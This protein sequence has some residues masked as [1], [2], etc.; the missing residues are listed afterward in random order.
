MSDFITLKSSTI[1]NSSF[2]IEGTEFLDQSLVKTGLNIWFSDTSDSFPNYTFK[3]FGYQDDLLF[4]DHINS[5]EMGSIVLV[6]AI[7]A[8]PNPPSDALFR[9][10]KKIGSGQVI[11][12]NGSANYCIIGVK[13]E[14]VGDAVE[15]FGNGQSTNVTV[16]RNVNPMNIDTRYVLIK[17]LTSSSISVTFNNTDTFES[18]IADGLTVW[19]FGED[20]NMDDVLMDSS[21]VY[22]TNSSTSQSDRLENFIQSQE[23]GKFIFIVSKGSAKTNISS[24]LAN[25]LKSQ[26]GSK[27]IDQYISSS[28]NDKWF[29]V[30]RKNSKYSL[31]ES[32]SKIE[33]TNIGS[34]FWTFDNPNEIIA[35]SKV[36]QRN[37]MISASS[38][39]Q[40]L[41]TS[42]TNRYSLI[43]DDQTAP[44]PTS[45]TSGFLMYILSEIDSSI[46]S[47]KSYNIKSTDPTTAV[48]M[49]TDIQNI[50]IGDIVVIIA[51]QLDSTFVMTSELAHMFETVGAQYSHDLIA[52]SSYVI[53][54]R[55]GSSTGSVPELFS[56][57]GPVSLFSNFSKVIVKPFIHIEAIS[58]S[59]TGGYSKFLINSTEVNANIANGINVLTLDENNGNIIDFTTFDTV[60]PSPMINGLLSTSGTFVTVNSSPS[61]NFNTGAFSAAVRFQTTSI[62]PILCRKPFNGGTNNGGWTL[63][64]EANGVINFM[65]DNGVGSYR[66]Q[67][68]PTNVIDADWHNIV[69]VRGAAGTL[70][71]YLDGVKLPVTIS[72]TIE[73]PL[74]VDSNASFVICQN[75]QKPGTQFIGTISDVSLWNSDIS[76]TTMKI[77]ASGQLTGNEPNLV[78]YWKLNSNLNDLS[79]V[80]NTGNGQNIT[81]TQ[82]GSTQSEL[83]ASK[84]QALQNGKIVAL[85]VLG[86][87]NT[88]LSKRAKDTMAFYLNSESVYT[89]TSG[90]SFCM[91]STI[92]PNSDLEYLLIS[93]CLSNSS[94]ETSC[95]VRFPIKSL[96]DKVVGYSFCVTSY[97]N[98]NTCKIMINGNHPTGSVG[99]GLN[100][101]TVDPVTG[102]ISEI[103]N[104]NTLSDPTAWS[105]FYQFISTLN[106]GVYICV[107]IKSSMGT[108]LTALDKRYRNMAFN[109]IGGCA[110]HNSNIGSYSLIGAKGITSG[111]GTES[112]S[113]GDSQVCVSSWEPKTP[114]NL[115]AS[116]SISNYSSI[117]SV[118]LL[119]KYYLVNNPVSMIPKSYA[120]GNVYAREPSYSLSNNNFGRVVKALLVAVSYKNS[121]AG[122]IQNSEIE[123][124]EHANVLIR[125][126]LILPENIKILSESNTQLSKD[127]TFVQ[128]PSSHCI[129]MEINDWLLKNI[130]TG[131]TIYFVY[132]G[133]SFTNTPFNKQ[134]GTVSDYGLC[135]LNQDLTATDYSLNR[136]TFLNLF[137]NVPTGVNI[138]MLLD[139][140]YAVDIASKTFSGAPNSI[141]FQIAALLGSGSDIKIRQLQQDISFLS[142][143]SNI[144]KNNFTSNNNNN[145]TYNNIIN[146][147]ISTNKY[148][149]TPFFVNGYAV[150]DD[151]TFLSQIKS[152]VS[153][154]TIGE[155]MD[156][157][158]LKIKQYSKNIDGIEYFRYSDSEISGWSQVN[159]T[160]NVWK[161]PMHESI[162]PFYEYN[163]DNSNI[164]YYTTNSNLSAE[165]GWNQTSI[166]GYVSNTKASDKIQLYQF[167]RDQKLGGGYFFST[168]RNESPN[169]F[170]FDGPT[171]F[172][173]L[174]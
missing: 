88:Y 69:I 62:G 66:V 43:I 72:K 51:S 171:V 153:D 144:L 157:N 63:V 31:C 59:V 135:S 147:V 39:N 117:H 132:K 120:V 77:A 42:V 116:Q 156:S 123:I 53:I 140:S 34:F 50:Q 105:N 111:T 19:T 100:V 3:T 21:Q 103:K 38:F 96:F 1:E 36:D 164:F 46:K 95:N 128:G 70:S 15:A 108:P 169:H 94:S 71:I 163:L 170:I 127:G 143:I 65:T 79:K 78:G 99:E 118:G 73:T 49:M 68:G 113:D 104:F 174:V 97:G 167:H 18:A 85:S 41:P 67:T 57:N 26:L 44:T 114:S 23:D 82:I 109:M 86:A 27:Y 148:Q 24:E 161:E 149:T 74:N 13:G 119:D 162:I 93:E 130:K 125:C 115:R 83:F 155:D 129:Q 40:G 165:Q 152:N 4:S 172:L 10:L 158:I 75:T 126:G 55:K 32:T 121:P 168:N 64:L 25:I 139:C 16:S 17:Q 112:F 122:T 37:V 166:I 141:Q 101:V 80:S 30:A 102:L 173:P 110:F 124:R 107:G 89:Y 61:Y 7:G 151:Q 90:N 91:I 81:Y 12:I 92:S 131:D 137:S 47:Y 48:A 136:S 134:P 28:T 33:Q 45:G 160:F 84:I 159:V 9:S 142:S 154:I 54:G 56:K 29:I 20:L 98:Q 22:S 11:S 2:E 8:F 14:A 150:T 87:A 76:Q 58:K 146:G 106:I 60:N 5:I 133:R 145:I 52:L 138:S 35:K 6:I